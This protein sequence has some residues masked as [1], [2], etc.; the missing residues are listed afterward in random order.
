MLRGSCLNSLRAQSLTQ[1]I[2]GTVEDQS[3]Q[4]P[5]LGVTVVVPGATPL[6]VTI[7]SASGQ[8]R[9]V[10]VPVGRQTLQISVV[11]Y[12]PVTLQNIS[13]DA[14]QEPVLAIALEEAVGQLSEVTVKPT[15]EKK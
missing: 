6:S 4:T 1:P 12:E 13:V 5:L 15:V 14:G 10:Q 3:L 11:G 9:S 8:F 2:R 7:T